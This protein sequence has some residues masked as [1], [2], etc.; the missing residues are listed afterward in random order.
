M[1]ALESMQ[2][3]LLWSCKAKRIT[4]L[5]SEVCNNNFRNAKH[6]GLIS[7]CLFHS[8]A[9]AVQCPIS[10]FRKSDYTRHQAS[11]TNPGTFSAICICRALLSNLFSC[12]F[13]MGV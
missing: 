8:A 1:P 5:C 10:F 11:G 12:P 2:R 6:T 9:P 7:L 4:L 13:R 3:K